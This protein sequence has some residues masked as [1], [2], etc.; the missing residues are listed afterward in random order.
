MA[1]IGNFSIFGLACLLMAGL[2]LAQNVPPP[3]TGQDNPDSKQPE[4]PV[5][6][7]AIT[8]TASRTGEEVKDVPQTVSVLGKEDIDREQATTP[9][10][11]LRDIP[12]IWSVQVASQGTPIIRGMMGNRVLYL[13]DGIRVNNGAL[14]SGP[15]GFFNQVPLGAVARMDVIRGPGAVQYGSDAMGGVVNIITVDL[16]SYP[17]RLS[18]G[19]DLNFVYGTVDLQKTG[20]ADFW[21]ANQRMGFTMGVTG[22]DVGNYGAPGVGTLDHTGFNAVGGY[23]WFGFRPK[24]THN[25]NATWVHDRRFDVE[26]YTQSKLNPGGI[27]RIFGP[28]EQR[29]LAKLSYVIEDACGICSELRTYAYGEYYQ[30]ARNQT[31]ETAALLNLTR[32]NTG[33]NMAG[34]GVQNMTQSGRVRLIYGSDY[35]REYLTS[36]KTLS[37][38]TKASGAVAVSIPNGNVPNGNYN[39]FDSFVLAQVRATARL[40]VSVGTRLE[41]TH[42]ISDPRTHDAIPP[43]TVETLRLDKWWVPLTWNAGAVYNLAGSWTLAGNIAA[44]FRAPTFSDTLSTGVPVF[45]SG[46]ASIPS[47]HVRPERSVTYEFGP[48][49]ASRNLNF[50]LTGYT[51]QLT[52]LLSSVPAGTIEIPGVGVVNALQ[53][54]NIATAYVRG[55]ESAMAY[56]F[57][58]QWTVF[59]NVTYTHGEDTRSNVPLRFIPPTFGAAGLRWV[60]P[61]NRFWGEARTIAAD[62]LRHHAPQDEIDSGFSTDPGFGSPSATNPPLRPGFQIPGFAVVTLRGGMNVWQERQRSLELTADINNLFNLRY[63]EAYSQ[64]QLLAPGLGAVLGARLRF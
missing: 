41:T 18:Y 5:L 33:Q 20:M 42:L 56:R 30:A 7:Q 62:R 8:V 59:A 37:A 45:A 36:D 55:I 44:G 34:L 48:R 21:V 40:T 61:H 10:A 17:P 24:P 63:R 60:H 14:F 6:L 25:F 47:P 23:A 15:N 52:D 26:S 9:N 49:Y 46:V 3:D 35:R 50:T 11:I 22:Q 53:N 13:W 58:P 2:C 43:F 1:R 64:Q 38:T 51:T 54:A 31:V 57:L 16:P 19:G 28:F 12:G 32:T 4:L 27:P 29:G 39:V